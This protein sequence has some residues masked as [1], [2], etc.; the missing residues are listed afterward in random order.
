MKEIAEKIG[1][2]D[3]F[4]YICPGTILLFSFVLWMRPDFKSPPWELILKQ[5]FL[6]ILLFSILAYTLGLLLSSVNQMMQVRYYR[7]DLREAGGIFRQAWRRTI[8][9][10]YYFPSPR[11]TPQL[12]DANLRIAEDLERL[13]GLRACKNIIS[14]FAVSGHRT[15]AC[16]R[17]GRMV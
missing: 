16:S 6:A 14:R 5:Q 9:F 2:S 17:R 12:V 10:L 8:R 11:M 15:R 7:L 13:A 4:A 1:L 3:F